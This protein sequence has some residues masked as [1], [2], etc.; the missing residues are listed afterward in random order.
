MHKYELS[1]RT[2]SIALK[3]DPIS[4]EAYQGMGEVHMR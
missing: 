3:F 2:Y 1:L 4:G